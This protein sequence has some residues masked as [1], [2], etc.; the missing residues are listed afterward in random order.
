MVE[1]LKRPGSAG[2][3]VEYK[4]NPI[5]FIIYEQ[6]EDM[7]DIHNIVVKKD[8]QRRGVGSQMIARVACR[9]GRSSRE[10]IRLAVPETNLNAQLFFRSLGFSAISI[11]RSPFDT[12]E[13]SYIMQY[14]HRQKMLPTEL[15]AASYE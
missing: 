8:F 4:E 3:V 1:V 10:M 11:E 13:D 15:V 6:T 12:D 14:R 7:L 2:M 5:G 9:L